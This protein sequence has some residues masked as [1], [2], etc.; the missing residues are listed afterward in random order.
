MNYLE[1]F[2]KGLLKENPV[3]VALLGMC[4][5]LA[6]TT[7]MSNA[8][9]MGAAVTVVLVMSNIVISLIRKIVPNDI[10]IPV[11]IVIMAAF[12]TMIELTMKAY[13]P[14]IYESLGIFIPLIVVNCVILARAE[15]FASRNGIIPSILD[16]LGMGLGYTIAVCVISFFREIIGTGKFLGFTLFGPEFE[17]A[18]IMILPPGA[19]ITLGFI[20]AFL[21]KMQDRKTS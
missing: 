3:F 12:V 15:A 14:A 18:L 8:I 11:F 19:F 4:S 20:L 10:R 21:N 6:I 7:S 1:T 13:V 17:P 2:T 16:G 5:V 9:G